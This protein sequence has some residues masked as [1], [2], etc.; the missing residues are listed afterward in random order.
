V[1]DRADAAWRPV[2]AGTPILAAAVGR[3]RVLLMSA[4]LARRLVLSRVLA[5]GEPSRGFKA[6]QS[7]SIRFLVR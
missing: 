6:V 2:G 1:R 3:R 4:A 5:A 7:Y